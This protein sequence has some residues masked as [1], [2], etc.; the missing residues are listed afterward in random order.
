VCVRE[1]GDGEVMRLHVHMVQCE[2]PFAGMGGLFV[3]TCLNV[4]WVMCENASVC[5]ELCM[6]LYS[7]GLA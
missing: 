1:G 7:C 6:H 3:C 4:V 5:E 2:G